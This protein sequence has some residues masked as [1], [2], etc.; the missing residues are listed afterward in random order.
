MASL[1]LGADMARSSKTGGKKGSA[2]TRK[3]RSAKGRNAAAKTKRPAKSAIRLKRSAASDIE[4][5]EARR[6]QAATAEILK[7]ISQSTFDLQAVLEALVKSA[8]QLCGADTGIIRRR[9]G[10]IYP[11]A[12]TFGFTEQERDFF[13]HYSMKPDR[14][15]VFGRAILEK[16]SIHVPDLLAD[17]DLNRDRVPRLHES[18]HYSHR[19]WCA[20]IARWCHYWGVH[21]ATT[22]SAAIY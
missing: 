7:A 18:R 15:S 9:E 20:A 12:A 3:A 1:T 2:A 14:G 19:A 10:E 4:L 16:R 21:T 13:S 11:V 8:V 22:K 6:Q 5:K 17:R